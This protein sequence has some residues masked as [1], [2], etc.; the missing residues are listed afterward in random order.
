MKDIIQHRKNRFTWALLAFQGGYVN[1]GGL[2]SLH[3]FVSHVT[4]FA[5]HFSLAMTSREWRH[6]LYF[7]LVPVFFLIGSFFSSVFTE[8]RRKKDEQP[9]YIHILSALSGVYLL[10][11]ILGSQ[12]FF[13]SFGEAFANFRDFMLLSSLAFSCGA[14]NAIFTHY[15]HSI[16]RTTHLTGLTTDLGIGLGRYFISRDLKEGQ[17]NKIRVDLIASFIA[18]SLLGAIV[19]PQIQFWGFL[20]PSALSLLVGLRLFITRVYY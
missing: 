3:I 7:L 2:L 13:G 17:L 11:S 5:A 18:G 15:S 19:F 6:S 12:N 1:V 20:I 9:V 8:I 4:G 16:I 10:I 14:Q